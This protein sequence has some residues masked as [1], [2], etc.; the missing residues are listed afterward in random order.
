MNQGFGFLWKTG[1]VFPAIL[2][3]VCVFA[4][5][6]AND[7][8]YVISID[9]ELH[10]PSFRNLQAVDYC[11]FFVALVVSVYLFFIFRNRRRSDF[12]SGSK[13]SGIIFLVV[14]IILI[15]V[16]ASIFIFLPG[17]HDGTDYKELLSS[18]EASWAVFA[19]VPYGYA[20]TEL[21]DCLQPPGRRH[22][23]GT[24]AVGSDVLCRI[25]HGSRVSLG[26]GF[27]SVGLACTTSVFVGGLLGY[28]GGKVD[29]LGMRVLEIFMAI[30]GFF[31]IITF[32]AFFPRSIMSVIIIISL[33]S[34]PAGARLIR[35]EFLKL[36]ETEF[37]QAAVCLG[38]PTRRIIFRHILSNGI[39][40]LLVN[41]TF[42]IGTAIFIEAALSYLGF[43][44]VPPTPSWGRMLGDSVSTSGRFLWWLSLFPGL[45]IFLTVLS[46]NFI[47]EWLY[48][49]IDGVRKGNG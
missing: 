49:S 19:P 4:P 41:A 21:K 42:G 44:A 38:L 20:R 43:G 23:L 22:L 45:A 24:D 7:K 37:V 46:F 12:I 32:S 11:M 39:S 18:G 3:F 27:V 15:F 2:V 1:V 34:W 31:L 47:G 6:I 28:F 16:T 30:P 48:D 36:R 9:D 40:P 29:F 10:Y 17:R 26:V 25:I 33:T 5:F 13:I 14:V 8:P 35:G